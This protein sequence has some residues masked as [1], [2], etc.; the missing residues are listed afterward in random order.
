M[1]YRERALMVAYSQQSRLRDSYQQNGTP[2]WK[3][4][5]GLVTFEVKLFSL[6][7]GNIKLVNSFISFFLKPDNMENIDKLVKDSSDQ[8]VNENV[9]DFS[10]SKN[11]KIIKQENIT[12]FETKSEFKTAQQLQKQNR[13][14]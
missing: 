9:T 10:D 4:S 5:M 8:F 12:S 14:K 6:I 13:L 2:C 7:I 3:E 1:K 11:T